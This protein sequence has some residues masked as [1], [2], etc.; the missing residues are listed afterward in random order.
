MKSFIAIAA[1]SLLIATP[2]LA[3]VKPCEALKGEIDTK[4]K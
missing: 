4:I 1:S 3:Q 2:A